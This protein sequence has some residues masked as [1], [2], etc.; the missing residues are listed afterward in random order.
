MYKII[1]TF[2]T[3]DSSIFKCNC[4]P[5]KKYHYQFKYQ[6]VKKM[7][8]HQMDAFRVVVK[9]NQSYYLL[10]FALTGANQMNLFLTVDENEKLQPK[11]KR[12]FAPDFIHR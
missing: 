3:Y 7:K 4:I 11:R 1:F 6:L 12:H 8:P 2:T 9:L 10:D 5:I